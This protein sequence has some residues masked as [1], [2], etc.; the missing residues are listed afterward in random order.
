[1]RSGSHEES[2]GGPGYGYRPALDGV[3]ALAITAVL[4]FHGGVALPGGFL[5]VDTFFVLSGFLITSLLLAE[6]DRHGRIRLAAF[7]GRRARR[8]LPALLVVLVVVAWA[9]HALLP[10]VEV[11]LLRGD[12]LS[13]LL[14]VA[15]WRMIYRGSDYFSR[16]A[17]PSPLQH[18]WSLGI[19]EQFYLLWPLLVVGAL[20]LLG[21]RR[22]RTGLLVGS[23]VGAAASAVAAALLYRPGDVNRDYFGTDTRAQALL[24]GCALA[25]VVSRAGSGVPA[26]AGAAVRTGVPARAD[27]TVRTGRHPV[28]G[29]LAAT[30]AA[31]TLA[32]W[33]LASGNS[34]WLYRDAGLA[35]AALAVAAVLAHAVLS[36]SSPTARLL[37]LAPLVALGRISYGVYLWHWPLF[38]FVTAARTGLSGVALLAVRLAMTLTVA[39]VSFVL[40][41]QPIRRG[42]GWWRRIVAPAHHGPLAR[43]SRAATEDGAGHGA[44]PAGARPAGAD[45]RVNVDPRDAS[46]RAGWRGFAGRL[47]SRGS[48]VNTGRAWRQRVPGAALPVLVGVVAVAATGAA[49]VAVTQPA[50]SA[51]SAA[52]QVSV[53]DAAGVSPTATTGGTSGRGVV[54]P[55]RRTGRVPGAEPRVDIFGDS[56]AW[57]IGAYL[58]DHPGIE[59]HNH[60][61][62]GCGITLLSDIKELGTPHRLYPY[63]PSW[64]GR[65]QAGVDADD[66]D[67]SVILLNRWELMDARLDGTYQH[68]GQPAFDGY[69]TG[70]LDQAI[71]I[72]GSR[73]ARVVLLTAAYTHRS[74]RP[75]GGLYDE[76]QPARVDAW[77]ALLRAE[78]AKHPDGIT[79]L[80]LNRLV[81]PDGTFTWDVD[82]IRIRSDGLHFTPAGVQRIIAPWLLPKLATIAATGSP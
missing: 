63:C 75:D 48:T 61:I 69:L 45:V 29:A 20:V 32:L 2:T 23:L 11:R 12:G 5:G 54:P 1:M 79:L 62:E 39:T 74:E 46:G 67:V 41:E 72:A 6:H 4:L 9:G 42:T 51:G 35:G 80:D 66:P 56:V 55:M 25:V 16:T 7:W 31:A 34:A 77:N 64:P 43:R 37:A 28:L 81:C 24:I 70:Q 19:E 36:P 82:G 13:A 52:I 18:T 15:N 59:V 50:G 17:A 68:I 3:R 53:P 33:L 10:P 38:Q 26:R 40:I 30:G 49:V 78:V 76:D 27:A 21:I 47:R 65:W 60:A 71:R 58:P 44:P 8:L 14:Y 57:T 73:G 22:G